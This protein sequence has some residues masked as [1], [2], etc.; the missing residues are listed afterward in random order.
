MLCFYVLTFSLANQSF[1]RQKLTALFGFTST[2][3]A[4]SRSNF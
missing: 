3:S 4:C 1:L 2:T